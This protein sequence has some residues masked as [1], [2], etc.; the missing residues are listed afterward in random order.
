MSMSMLASSQTLLREIHWN[1]QPRAQAVLW[2]TEA[3]PGNPTPRSIW[4]LD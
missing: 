4:A 3:L 2:V 1:W